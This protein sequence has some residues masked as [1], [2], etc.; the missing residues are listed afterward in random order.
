MM[1]SIG[2]AIC[3]KSGGRKPEVCEEIEWVGKHAASYAHHRFRVACKYG[4]VFPSANPRKRGK[5][6]RRALRGGAIELLR[7]EDRGFANH[8][9]YGR[10]RDPKYTVLATCK[11]G[12]R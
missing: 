7:V 9:E 4:V 5:Q 10:I 2:Y 6:R 11:R 12:A 3:T 8:P 1:K